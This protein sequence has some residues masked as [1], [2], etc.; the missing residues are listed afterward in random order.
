MSGAE[1]GLSQGRKL[2]IYAGGVMGDE[3]HR[4]SCASN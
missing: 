3:P 2:T 1:E 4:T